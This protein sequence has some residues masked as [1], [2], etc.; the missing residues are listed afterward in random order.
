MKVYAEAMKET[1]PR[2]LAML[3]DRIA[4]N[5]GQAQTTLSQGM[6]VTYKGKTGWLPWQMKDVKTEGEPVTAKA[7]TGEQV[8]LVKW[9]SSEDSK[10]NTA[11]KVQLGKENVE[12]AKAAGITINLAAYVEHVMGTDFVGN[13]MIKK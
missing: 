5:T 2:S 11:I 6:Q 9:A 12:K 3:T 8:Q 7:E 13:W 1:D 4:V 10:I